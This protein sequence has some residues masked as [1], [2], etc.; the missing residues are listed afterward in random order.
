[1]NVEALGRLVIVIALLALCGFLLAT[2]GSPV[3]ERVPVWLVG[4]TTAAVGNAARLQFTAKPP[5]P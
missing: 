4:L 2:G 1:L 5:D 3:E